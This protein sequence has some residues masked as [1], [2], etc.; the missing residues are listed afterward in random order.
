[1]PSFLFS[2][3]ANN[4]LLIYAKPIVNLYAMEHG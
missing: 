1:M 2:N 3:E 4:F